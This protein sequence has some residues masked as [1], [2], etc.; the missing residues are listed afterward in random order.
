MKAYDD[1]CMFL[2]RLILFIDNYWVFRYPNFWIVRVCSSGFN[3]E[4]F[5]LFE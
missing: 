4:V 1:S 3:I 5:I 2:N